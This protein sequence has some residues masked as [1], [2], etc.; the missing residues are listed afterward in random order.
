MYIYTYKHNISNNKDLRRD[1][2]AISRGGVIQYFIFVGR[3]TPSA[4]YMWIWSFLSDVV[5]SYFYRVC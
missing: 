4:L 3:G 2:Q 1:S 5:I